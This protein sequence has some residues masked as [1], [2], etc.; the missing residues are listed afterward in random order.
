MPAVRVR[1]P[2]APVPLTAKI[3]AAGCYATQ[4]RFQFG[5]A[6]KVG[7]VLRE[8]AVA[9]GERVGVDGA[10]EV[11]SLPPGWHAGARCGSHWP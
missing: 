10:A 4:L 9:E 1:V 11:F 6:D 2:V 3:E 8:L 7:P 5:G